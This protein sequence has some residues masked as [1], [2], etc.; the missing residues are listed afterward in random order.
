LEEGGFTENLLNQHPQS[1]SIYSIDSLMSVDWF[2]GLLHTRF[3]AWVRMYEVRSLHRVE[4]NWQRLFAA[5]AVSKLGGHGV[6]SGA[7]LRD[8]SLPVAIPGRGIQVRLG[9]RSRAV[10][11]AKS[12]S[13]HWDGG[14]H[15]IRPF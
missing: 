11:S 10:L 14:V 5:G 12:S 8:G 2:T 6:N 1:K 3:A 13:W 15:V 9:F 7:L 4:V